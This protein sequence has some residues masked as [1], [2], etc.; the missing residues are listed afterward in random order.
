[1]QRRIIRTM[2][3][4]RI[5]HETVNI[6]MYIADHP[7]LYVLLNAFGNGVHQT[8]CARPRE[9]PVLTQTHR[10]NI[11]RPRQLNNLSRPTGTHDITQDENKLVFLD[12]GIRSTTDL[13]S[14]SRYYSAT[15][16]PA[17]KLPQDANAAMVI[18]I[19]AHRTH[20]NM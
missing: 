19:V 9:V 16:K 1:M 17:C 3:F 7:C 18:S 6:T 5:K 14:G 13:P 2:L 20:I 8:T 10:R 15:F 11:Q 4:Q 12:G